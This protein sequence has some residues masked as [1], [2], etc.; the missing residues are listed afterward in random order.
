MYSVRTVV[1]IHLLTY[2]CIPVH[3]QCISKGHQLWC[4]IGNPGCLLLHS[5]SSSEWIRS[6]CIQVR[7]L[8]FDAKPSQIPWI[9]LPSLIEPQFEVPIPESLQGSKWALTTE[10]NGP[11]EGHLIEPMK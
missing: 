4:N 6:N 9:P 2:I 8:V 11:A 10:V 1:V 5:S 3:V 7:V